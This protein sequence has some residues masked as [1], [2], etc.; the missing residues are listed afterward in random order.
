MGLESMALSRRAIL[1]GAVG[2]VAAAAFPARAMA[3]PSPTDSQRQAMVFLDLMMDA[4]AD[5]GTLRLPQSYTD[6]V[7]LYAT[8]F[9]YDIAL[10]VLAY[11]ADDRDTSEDRAAQLGEALHYAQQHD[12]EFSDGR[13]R[14]AYNV[15]PYTRNGVEHPDGFVHDDGTVNIGGAFGFTASDTG[16][17][18]WTGLAHCALHR[19]TGDDRMLGS[20]MRLG[21]WIADSC[22]SHRS[23][24][25]FSAGVDRDGTSRP[26]VRTAHNAALVALFGQLAEITGDRTWLFERDV[27]R[28]FVSRMWSPVRQVFLSGAI[29]GSTP[30]RN[31]IVLEAQTHGWLAS[32]DLDYIGCLDTVARQLT[33]TDT[34]A[35]LNSALTGTQRVTGVTVSSAS[36]TADPA[37]PIEPGLPYPDRSAVWL[38]GTAQFATA[39][40]HSPDGSRASDMRLRTLTDAQTILGADQT[41]AGR[42]IPNGAGLVAATSPLHVGFLNSGYYPAKHVAATAWYVLAVADINPLA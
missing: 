31:T 3:Q 17:Q 26:E 37:V 36:R 19:R 10:A 9:T 30:D 27:A 8:A 38:E 18:A 39:L 13:V 15:G 12:P 28:S 25:G 5:A 23:L 7:G 4:H 20:A 33:V 42:P 14:Q 35:A 2:V 21:E 34:A 1:G 22:R 41:V 32:T 6:Q 40:R 16:T 11:L 29:D 24:G